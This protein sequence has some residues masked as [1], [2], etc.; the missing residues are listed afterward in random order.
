[1]ELGNEKDDIDNFSSF[2]P[3][4]G[5]KTANTHDYASNDNDY[6][7]PKRTS[8]RSKSKDKDVGGSS[9]GELFIVIEDDLPG[10]R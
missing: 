4:S 1:M 3:V 5:A 8:K 2:L 9:D 6:G 10:Y 7:L